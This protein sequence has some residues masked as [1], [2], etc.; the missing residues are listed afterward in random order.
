MF[1]K[2]K[3]GTFTFHPDTN[4]SR[5]KLIATEVMGAFFAPKPGERRLRTDEDCYRFADHLG[6]PFKLDFNNLD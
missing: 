3:L 4:W 6:E 5:A 1:Y 2:N